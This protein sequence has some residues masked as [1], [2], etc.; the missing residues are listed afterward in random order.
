LFA[1]FWRKKLQRFDWLISKKCSD[2]ITCRLRS[3]RVNVRRNL[4]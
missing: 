3:I 2:G 4:G 1:Q